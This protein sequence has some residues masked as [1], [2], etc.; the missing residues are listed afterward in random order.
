MP[1]S[2]SFDKSDTGVCNLALTYFG[3][4]KI[5]AL[6]SE[7]TEA[8]IFRRFY[9][10]VRDLLLQRVDWNWCGTVGSLT[11]LTNDY[12]ERWAYKY[13][14]GN[15]LVFRGIV[16]SGVDLR[17]DVRPTPYQFTN[18][19]I[20]TDVADAKGR[21]TLPQT[22]PQ[23][24]PAYFIQALAAE[25][26]ARAV[27]PI[28]RDKELTKLVS[29]IAIADRAVALALDANQDFHIEE[30]AADWHEARK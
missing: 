15:W 28:T 13:Q 29:E 30:Y 17:F 3:N 12:S 11:P 14:Y 6:S 22:N 25:L 1:T 27:M 24:W 7:E 10:Q 4:K 23:T 26:A 5:E 2:T 20:Y 18:G 21:W 9:T 19:A 8:K 16:R